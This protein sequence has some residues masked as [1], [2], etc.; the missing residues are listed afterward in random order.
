MLLFDLGGVLIANRTFEVLGEWLPEFSDAH[1]RKRWL[2]S[3][4]VRAFELGRINRVAFSKRFIAEWHLHLTNDDFLHEF[5]AWPTGFFP[6]AE[7]ALSQ[8]RG[9]Y[10]VCCL[11]NAN[12]IHWARFNG[13]A[14]YF[15]RAFS[16][17]LLGMI[18]PDRDVFEHVI[19]ELG[20]APSEIVFF[21]DSLPNIETA[22]LLG[23]QA[24]H[25]EGFAAVVDLMGKS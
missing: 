15:D 24:H 18:K 4:A 3:D 1:I 21:D 19:G 8:W 5:A 10:Q 16:S 2:E 6:G 17:H 13:F 9:R 20:A 7:A 14:P 11:S 22:R 23:M 12:E 25:V